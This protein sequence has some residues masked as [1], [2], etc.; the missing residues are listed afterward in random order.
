MSAA[1]VR[2]AGL[3]GAAVL[4]FGLTGC[5]MAAGPWASAAD[6]PN[7]TSPIVTGAPVA[8]A[9]PLAAAAPVGLRIDSINASSTLVPL[10]LNANRTVTVPP[11]ATPMQAS[12]YRLGPAP[13]APGPAVILG[14]VNGDGKEGI[15][16]RLN[17]VKPGDQVK[18][19]RAD[20][21]TAVFTVTKLQQVAKNAFPTTAVYG[22]T[23]AAELRLVTC[24]GDF[25]QS[26]HSYADSIIAFATLTSV[27]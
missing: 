17:E 19:S 9:A 27:A 21:K 5:G 14:H 8:P 15:F 20:G 25:D 23:P 18:V 16:A 6:G 26:K 7:L 22:D 11:V 24:G 3:V 10:G 2:L 13:G 1:R 12:W 4:S